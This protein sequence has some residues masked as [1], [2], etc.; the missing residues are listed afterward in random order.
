M[1]SAIVNLISIP[2][3]FYGSSIKKG[4]IDLKFYV[5]GN[6]IAQAKDEKQ[7]GVLVQTGPYGSV[8]SGSAVGLALYNE[9]FLILTASS[10]ILS[11]NIDSYEGS[12]TTPKWVHFA[13]T[14]SS[15]PSSSFRMTM[16]GTNYIPALTMMAHAPKAELNYSNNPTYLSYSDT[17]TK[18]T[19]TGSI[20]FAQS[21]EINIKNMW[22]QPQV[23]RNKYTFLR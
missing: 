11:S 17:S 21:E 18:K 22:I 7:N 15:V 4:T 1:S 16:E 14:G 13:S 12:A 23:F 9:G 8:G 10:N 19:N 5:T 6:L 3:I 2:S 20:I